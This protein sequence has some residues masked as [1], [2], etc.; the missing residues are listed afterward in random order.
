VSYGPITHAGVNWRRLCA[1][2]NLDPLEASADQVEQAIRNAIGSEI[3]TP[4]RE[5]NLK[6]AAALDAGEWLADRLS[7]DSQPEDADA[8]HL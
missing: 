7:P 3:L 5:A 2:Y 8:S 6:I 1:K 4:I